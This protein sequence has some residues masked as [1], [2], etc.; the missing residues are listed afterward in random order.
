MR[1]TKTNDGKQQIRNSIKFKYM[2]V[3]RTHNIFHF[4]VKNQ[5]LF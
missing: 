4:I 2:Y 3:Q 5:R 1:L